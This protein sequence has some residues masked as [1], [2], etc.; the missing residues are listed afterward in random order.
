MDE[1][2]QQ[3]IKQLKE[4]NAKLKKDIKDFSALLQNFNDAV[5]IHDFD[6]EIIAWDRGAESIFGWKQKEL[7]GTSIF[8]II[9]EDHL[10]TYQKFLADIRQNK[11]YKHL[12]TQKITNEGLIK[13]IWVTYK[14]LG[15]NEPYAIATS[16]RDITDHKRA[17]L[18]IRQSEE[19][20]A[21][22]I[23]SLG[24]GIILLDK[25]YNVIF[26]NP[27]AQQIL[28]R[29]KEL[30]ENINFNKLLDEKNLTLFKQHVG[31]WHSGA[32]TFDLEVLRYDGAQ[33]LLQLTLSAPQSDVS[34]SGDILCIMKD[35]TDI[36]EMEDEIIKADK[37][38]SL[39][40]L[41]GGI[42][43]DFNNILSIIGGNVTLAEMCLDDKEKMKERLDRISTANERAKQ[44][45]Y[46]ISTLSKG[47][48]VSKVQVSIE[49]II[50]ESVALTLESQKVAHGL[51][52]EENLPTVNA[53]E[54]Q[55][56]QIFNNLMINAMHA[57]DEKT[58]RVDVFVNEV[59]LDADNQYKLQQGDY[60]RIVVK[61][62]GCGIPEENLRK[63]FDPYFTTK[64]FGTG[65]GL[66]TSI[67]IIN[68]HNGRIKVNSKVNV[69]TTF[70]IFLPISEKDRAAKEEKHF[71]TNGKILFMDDEVSIRSI[72]ELFFQKLNYKVVLAG[73][74]QE[75][76]NI[77]K[78][79]MEQNAPFDFVFLD[80]NIPNGMDGK[81]CAREILKINPDAKIIAISGNIVLSEYKELGFVKALKKPF[82]I[83]GIKSILKELS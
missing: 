76:L 13:D 51:E 41:A 23:N 73:E 72:A 57:I 2:L 81:T 79:Q 8:K 70:F 44:L 34:Q 4:E 77:Y 21:N 63:I 38:E 82:R 11:F 26:S 83:A 55:L 62:N 60:I 20:Y 74:G 37:L 49:K 22:L 7:L 43:H 47:H 17:A 56:S 29:D 35:I 25:N 50:R 54:G 28:F 1:K 6:G 65:L 52:I 32:T 64:D 18:K 78:N 45:T 14:V 40:L 80:L 9:P 69:G 75:A 59:K 31:S 53:D 19:K 33:R 16:E 48:S 24:E 15:G 12:E 67:S 10:E 36:R 5:I 71:T 30:M 46:Q 61:D 39:G 3:Q 58:G 68:K 27:A 42:A 66:S